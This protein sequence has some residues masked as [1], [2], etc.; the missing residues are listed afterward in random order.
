MADP[1]GLIIWL[2]PE[3]SGRGPAPAFDRDRLAAAGVALADVDGLAAVTMRAVAQALGAGSASLYRYVATREE[4]LELMIDQAVGELGPPEP[5]PAPGRSLD[6]LLA[7]ARQD[8]ELYLRHPWLLEATAS[9][10]PL[11]PH[12]VTRLEYALAAL[13]GLPLSAGA[14]LEALSV[15]NAV[16]AALSR[17]EAAQRLAGRTL[18]QWQQAQQDYLRQVLDS[19]RHPHLAAAMGGCGDGTGAERDPAELVFDRVVG[20][21]LNGLLGERP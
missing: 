21:V 1:Q 4:L 8:R 15:L 9:R 17:T 19:G 6:G 14:K 2:R 13:A 20:K 18:P 7:L 5:A 10:S 3:R 16:V 11:G 12:A